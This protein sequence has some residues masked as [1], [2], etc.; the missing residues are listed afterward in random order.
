MKKHFLILAAVLFLGCGSTDSGGSL[1]VEVI[2]GN[3]Q[4]GLQRTVLGIPVIVRVTDSKGN[5]GEGIEL[6][7][8]GD[9]TVNNQTL[10]TNSEGELA[11]D[12]VL[13]EDLTQ[14]I[15]ISLK[16]TPDISVFAKAIA[17]Y[18][19]EEPA[20]DQD[21]W[22]VE[23]LN[24][25]PEKMAF[26]NAGMDNVRNEVFGLIHGVVIVHDKKLVLEDYYPGRNSSGQLINF[27]R[28][29]PHEIQSASKS[30]RSMMT[31]IAIEKGFIQD[32]DVPFY[33]LFPGSASLS[34]P[35]KNTITLDHVLTMS[36]GLNWNEWSFPFGSPN[37]N[38]S[39][40]Y[41]LP[42]SQWVQYV[43]GLPM[44][45]DPGSKFEYSTGTSLLLADAIT[46]SINTDLNTFATQYYI[47]LVE[48]TVT[49]DNPFA[50]AMTPRQMAKMGYIYLHE[51]KWKDTQIV[52]QEWID[53]SI[54]PRFDITDFNAQYGYQWWLRDFVYDGV[55]YP[56]YYAAG[57]G[58][59]HV[60]VIKDLDLVVTLTGGDFGQSTH[61]H[62]NFVANYVIPAFKN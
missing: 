37:N 48:G 30:F 23:E 39:T 51:G 29:T 13:G 58:G 49:N 45:D 38:L 42:R 1:S 44:R 26:L 24:L 12:W 34:N 43:L 47:S 33:S 31:G 19:Y 9:G 22:I 25:S 57:N 16:S 6:S 61:R 35:V 15:T 32:E 20:T 8:I 55:T 62:F 41:S 28:T 36:S 2:S 60:F 14:E 40:L 46:N 10:V 52:S 27:N 21:G 7:I 5:P 18:N 4:Q 56:S 3:N 59:Q 17:S 54:T 53:K 50:P 11:I